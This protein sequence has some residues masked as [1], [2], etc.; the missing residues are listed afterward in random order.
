MRLTY[1]RGTLLI[2]TASFNRNLS[3]L[4]GIRWDSRVNKFRAPG[5]C[6]SLIQNEL[7][8]QQIEFLE[9]VWRIRHDLAKWNT[10]ELRPYQSAA[11]ASWQ[12]SGERG[13]VVLP[14]G[15]G[16]TRLGLTAMARL[17]K[18][19]LCL[20]PTRV[21]MYQ[22]VDEIQKFYTGP[23]GIYGDGNRKCEPITVATFESAYRQMGLLGNQF[24]FLIIDEVHHFLS[25][26]RTE[27]L[28]MS[29]APQRLGLTA[30]LSN[31]ALKETEIY[32]LVG[33]MVYELNIN[34]LKGTYLSNF[35]IISLH[36]DLTNWERDFYTVEI[37]LFDKFQKRFFQLCPE[38]RWSD[39]ARHASKSEVGKRAMIG[40]QRIKKLLG[41]TQQKSEM[42]TKLL[43]RHHKE[44]T[45][46][47][48]S[49]TD[50][51]CKIAK[52]HL[53]MPLTCDIK[54]KE[55][56]KMLS[57]FRERKINTLVSCR[58]LNEGIDVPDAEVA[59]IVGGAL[60]KREYIQR[61]GRLLRPLPGKKAIIYE[62]VSRNTIEVR[63]FERMQRSLGAGIDT[64]IQ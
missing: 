16:K 45:F 31:G 55:R 64:Q 21:L 27:A 52:N 53:V 54:K 22:W 62:L 13:I 5:Y 44:K 41:F 48:T 49:N 63:Q 18:S 3:G 50:T 30:T 26:V 12:L 33:P 39:M 37:D 6:Y 10:P 2:E 36:L 20:V 1:D 35:E 32:N 25:G 40:W 57:F 7:S 60:G 34:D 56:D 43:A 8:K 38:G 47:F 24:E 51:A 14:T 19:T 28:Q 15:A 23:V 29:I 61:I 4:P 17:K 46:I 11:L 9:S 59:I 42:L 58:V